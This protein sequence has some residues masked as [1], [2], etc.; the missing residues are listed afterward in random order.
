[1]LPALP[2]HP[3][4]YTIAGLLAICLALIASCRYA[5]TSTNSRCTTSKNRLCDA[6]WGRDARATH[7]EPTDRLRPVRRFSAGHAGK[8]HRSER[9]YLGPYAIVNCALNLEH[10]AS[11]PK[12]S[13][14][15]GASFILHRVLRFDPPHCGKISWSP[16]TADLLREGYRAT[17]GHMEPN[18]L[19]RH[20]DRDR[21]GRQ[22]QRRLSH[23]SALAFLMTILNVRLGWWLGNRA[24]IASARS[25]PK[26][27]LLPLLSELF[28]QSNGRSYYVNV[29]M[30]ATRQSR[31]YEPGRALPLHRGAPRRTR[32]RF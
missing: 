22:P 17:P 15:R 14:R 1:M 8:V 16:R 32:S 2:N 20:R 11:W 5:S 7:A 27:A 25:G 6:S 4:I 26:N 28:A 21:G 23:V 3:L 29:L 9:S 30:A 19:D 10:R 12:C 31:L 18:G 13:E 24:A